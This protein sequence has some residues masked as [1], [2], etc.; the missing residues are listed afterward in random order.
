M[1]KY[2]WLLPVIVTAGGAYL[3][4]RSGILNSI[5]N[6][7][8]EL[9]EYVDERIGEYD[10]DD[11]FVSKLTASKA[12]KAIK[13]AEAVAESGGDLFNTLSEGFADDEDVNKKLKGLLER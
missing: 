3:L 5:F 2:D 7:K 11:L 9:P 13:K 10:E 12:A 4:L 8:D 1:G 6:K